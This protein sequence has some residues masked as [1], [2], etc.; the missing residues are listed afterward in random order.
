MSTPDLAQVIE[1]DH[2]ALD[3]LVRGRRPRAQEEAV[4]AARRRHAGKSARPACPRLEPARVGPWSPPLL[5][6]ERASPFA[7]NASR[8]TRRR[9]LRTSSSWSGGVAR[10]AGSTR[11]CPWR[12]G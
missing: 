2:R 9:T 4:L 6:S 8:S 7:S 11:W 12:F 1:Q 10:S 3:A 5:S